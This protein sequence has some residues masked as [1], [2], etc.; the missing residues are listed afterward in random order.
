MEG[1]VDPG[2]LLV[3]ARHHARL[4]Q[5]ELARRAGT[6]RPTLS[7]YEHNRRSPT[8]QTASRVLGAAGF[9]LIAAP[10]VEFTEHTTGRG[11]TIT[12]PS[13]LPRLCPAQALATVTLPLHVNWSP[14]ARTFDLRTRS[15]R[16]RVYEIVLR[17]GT[18]EDILAYIDG[19]LLVELWDDLILPRDVRGAWAPL[20]QQTVTVSV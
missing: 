20:I 19:V 5:D 2:R 18:G 4:S 6:S 8:L 1:I 9:E 7:A 16:A 17:E 15:D 12:V 10:R 13:H 11:R 3:E 14:P